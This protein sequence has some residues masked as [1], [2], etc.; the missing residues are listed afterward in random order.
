MK[1]FILKIIE[2]IYM[3]EKQQIVSLVAGF[4]T[5]LIYG[6][7]YTYGTLIPYVASYLYYAGKIQIKIGDKQITINGMAVLLT[8]SIFVLNIGMP[9]I[10]LKFLQFS[11]K[12]TAL[13][14]ICG[15]CAS[16]FCLSFLD[17]FIYYIIFYGFTFGLFI[18]FGYLAPIKNCY[19]HIPGKKGNL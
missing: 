15:V 16:I 3:L 6:S 1:I 8:V 18:G 2:Y 5:M 7:S 11:N 19:E 10:N 14:S 17:Q 13:I 9:I 12:I 4:T